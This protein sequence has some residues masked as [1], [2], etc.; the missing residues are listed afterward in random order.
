MCG[1]EE[2]EGVKKKRL[3][4]GTLSSFRKRFRQEEGMCVFPPPCLPL[5]LVGPSDQEGSKK[6]EKKLDLPNCFLHTV[7]TKRSVL[8]GYGCYR[9]CKM[10]NKQT[11]APSNIAKMR[12]KKKKKLRGPFK[13]DSK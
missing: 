8:L 13:S 3:C 11:Q 10:E 1:G 6:K 4:S 9:W 2:V 12:L 5:T 7:S